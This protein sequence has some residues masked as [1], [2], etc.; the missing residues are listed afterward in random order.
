MEQK[1]RKETTLNKW[2]A[3]YSWL[4]TLT[5]GQKKVICT[6]CT[7]QEEKLKLMPRANL[8]FVTGKFKLSTL[9]EHENT[10]GHK[11]AIPEEENDKTP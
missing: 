1:I 2:E 10:D 11:R 5:L 6:V 3:K 9:K 4:K 7:S 8:T